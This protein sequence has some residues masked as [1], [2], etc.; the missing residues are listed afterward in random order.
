MSFRVFIGTA[1]LS[2]SP[3]SGNSCSERGRKIGWFFF[4]SFKQEGREATET[5][6]RMHDIDTHDFG[7]F[8]IL[9]YLETRD[10]CAKDKRAY[11]KAKSPHRFGPYIS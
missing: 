9:Y 5:S 8:C 6:C 3:P 2:L 7:I 1:E 10:C 11:R 4:F